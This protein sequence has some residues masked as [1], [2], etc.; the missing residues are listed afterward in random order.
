MNYFV[1]CSPYDLALAAY[2]IQEAGDFQAQ[3]TGLVL[4][5]AGPPVELDIANACDAMLAL[6]HFAAPDPLVLCHGL[7][8]TGLELL[9]VVQDGIGRINLAPFQRGLFATDI[10]ASRRKFARRAMN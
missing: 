4:L 6:V 9:V 5:G 3:D 8:T 2:L 10:A 1:E 7:Y